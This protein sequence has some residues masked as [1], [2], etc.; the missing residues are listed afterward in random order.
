MLLSDV[1]EEIIEKAPHTLSPQSIVRKINQVRDKLIRTYGR[2]VV[3]YRMDIQEG[4]AEYPWPYSPGSIVNVLV[5]GVRYPYGQFNARQGR[6]FYILT[7]T[8]GIYPTPTKDIEQG[9]TIF[10]KKTLTPLTLNDM[11][12][13][14]GFD[15]DYDMLVVYGVLT[16]ITSGNVAAEYKAKYEDILSDYLRANT[17]PEA[18]QIQ[19][20]DW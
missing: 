6:Y 20:V 3:P 8:I 13:E 11:N 12:A 18:Y 9:L 2:D 17:E 19:V 10:H 7:G 4:L 14:I 16:D 1:M 15:P 5:D